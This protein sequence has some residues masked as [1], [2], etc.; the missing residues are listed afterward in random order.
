MYS[1]TSKEPVTSHCTH[2]G[3][4][5]L[6]DNLNPV[7]RVYYSFSTLLCTPCSRSQEVGLCLGAQSG[8]A[9]IRGVVTS[10][11]FSRFRRAT[12]TPFNNPILLN[13]EIVP[14]RFEITALICSAFGKRKK[15][16]WNFLGA[17]LVFG[18]S[19][20]GNN[21]LAHSVVVPLELVTV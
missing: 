6:K 16:R 21:K 19:L 11:G 14:C 17:P 10:A 13:L 18:D 20:R 1:V 5:E 3:S 8:E 9:R 12:E 15:P 7:G 2:N 4:N